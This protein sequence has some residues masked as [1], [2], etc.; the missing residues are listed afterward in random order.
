LWRPPDENGTL[1]GMPFMPEMLEYCGRRYR[2]YEQAHKTCDYSTDMDARVP[3]VVHLDG[4]RCTREAHDGCQEECLLFWKEASLNRMD[5]QMSPP[6][7]LA[8]RRMRRP[9]KHPQFSAGAP[10]LAFSCATLRY[11]RR[12]G[13]IVNSSTLPFQETQPRIKSMVIRAAV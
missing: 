12:I 11:R 3:S 6:P 2:V 5:D 1:E 8:P 13:F 4:L 9:P 7:Q 10:M